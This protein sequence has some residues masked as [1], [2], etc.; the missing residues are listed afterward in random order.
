[1]DDKSKD[2]I[3]KTRYVVLL[4]YYCNNDQRYYRMVYSLDVNAFRL[5]FKSLVK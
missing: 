1:M 4:V 5:A 2:K 3:I